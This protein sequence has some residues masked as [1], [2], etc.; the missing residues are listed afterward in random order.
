MTRSI[1]YLCLA[2]LLVCS[3]ARPDAREEFRKASAKENGSYCFSI[4]MRDTLC[5]YD[6]DLCTRIDCRPAEFASM[7][8]SIMMNMVYTSPSGRKFAEKFA[9]AKDSFS[10]SS[11]FSKEYIIPYRRDLVPA[12]HGIWNLCIT[13]GNE[14]RFPGMR[15]IGIQVRWKR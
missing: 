3:C 7:P 6:L 15:G 10:Q 2:A 4:D 12:E 13:V 1:R 5:S 11:S 14:N 8:D 9:A